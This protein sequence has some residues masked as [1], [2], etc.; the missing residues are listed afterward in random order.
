MSSIELFLAR[1]HIAY[2]SMEIALRQSEM[3]T[4]A[5]GLGILAG[6]TARSCGD[7]ELPVVFVTLASRAGYF[8]QV[9]DAEGRQSE[10]P[11]WWEPQRWCTPLPAAVAVEIANRS[12]WIR[13]WLYVST[14]PHGYRIPILLL[15]TDLDANGADDRTLTDF[16]YGG[17]ETYRLK[18]EIILGIGGV[19]ILRALGFDLHT[20]HMNE[21]HAALLTLE[22]LNHW[23]VSPE[24]LI[25]GEA[26]YD[27]AEVRARCVF[28]THTPVEAGQDRFPYELFERLLPDFIEIDTLKRLAGEDRLNMTRLALNLSDYVN[29]VAARHAETTQHMFPGYRIH[30]ITNGVHVGTWAHPAFAQLYDRH[31]PLWRH[32]PEHL[33]RALQMP[34][35]EVWQCHVAARDELIAQVKS[36]TGTIL[37]PAAPILG[38]A[39]RMTG[40][41]R[42]LLLFSN[43]DRLRAIAA[44]RPFQLVMAGKAHPRDD[45]GKEA[46]HRLFELF[47][48]LKGDIPCVFLPN[49]D[50][51]LA[52][53]LVTGSDIWLNTPLPPLEASGTSGMKAALN[54]VLNLSILDGWW[55]EACIEGVTGW[56]IGQDGDGGPDEKSAALLYDKLEG[57]VL[58]LYTNDPA[59]WRI[60]MKQAI[61]HIASYFN[62]HRMMRRYATEAY[63]R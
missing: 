35:D 62:S 34:E 45:E 11:D 48:R 43:I 61:A 14:A 21:G 33:V 41:K 6:D 51:E 5:G 36:V 13:P 1:T 10:E 3:H 46:I 56:S 53:L 42:P 7:L 4:Y 38:F 32:E 29:G 39:R 26:P 37:D 25:A 15:D 59:R 57:V 12:V 9:L 44:R 40:Y 2:F 8:R 20:Y 63:L 27:I 58:P 30:A 31:I 18:Q 49:Y 17:D 60:M 50:I 22:L 52:K 54:G 16:L 19:R 55:I 23:R 28:T 47:A 24:E